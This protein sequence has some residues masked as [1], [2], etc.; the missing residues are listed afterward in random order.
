LKKAGIDIVA[1]GECLIDFVSSQQADTL[2]LEGHPD[3]AG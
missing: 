2:I 3:H 1:V